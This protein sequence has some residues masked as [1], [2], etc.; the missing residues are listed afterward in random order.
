MSLGRRVQ[1]RRRELGLKQKDLAEL[2]GIAQAQLGRLENGYNTNPSANLLLKLARTLHCSIDWLLGT[3]DEIPTVA[4]P[5]V[6][7]ATVC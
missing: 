1:Q 3:Y 2:L 6:A 4:T 5:L 7:V